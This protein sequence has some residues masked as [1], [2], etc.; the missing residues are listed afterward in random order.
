MIGWERIPT[1]NIE[2]I[3]TNFIIESNLIVAF[4]TEL[5]LN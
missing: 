2:I 5:Y 1:K 3:L 4:F